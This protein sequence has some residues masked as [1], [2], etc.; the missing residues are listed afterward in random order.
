MENYTSQFNIMK[1]TTIITLLIY[2][3]LVTG[4]KAQ[5]NNEHSDKSI[6]LLDDDLTYWY[7]WIGVQNSSVEGLPE[8]T[9]KGDGMEGT[10]AHCSTRGAKQEFRSF[11]MRL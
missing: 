2:L 9:P 1:I 4:A 3:F 6:N 7:K 8:G 10:H 11:E 5:T